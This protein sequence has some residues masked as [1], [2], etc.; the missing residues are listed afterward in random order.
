MTART[1]LC[2]CWRI[3]HKRR[4]SD[5]DGDDGAV[6]LHGYTSVVSW[7]TLVPESIRAAMQR[8]LE[9]AAR[10]AGWTSPEVRD[11]EPVRARRIPVRHRKHM[12]R[13]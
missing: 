6:D 10:H 4:G 11:H 9:R 12:S 13:K 2:I 7:E 1:S 8:R 5:E 3:S